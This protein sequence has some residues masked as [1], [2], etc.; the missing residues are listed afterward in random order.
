MEIERGGLLRSG[1]IL[2]RG[3][4]WRE[5]REEGRWGKSQRVMEPPPNPFQC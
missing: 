4:K 1:G 3:V 5:E 2:I